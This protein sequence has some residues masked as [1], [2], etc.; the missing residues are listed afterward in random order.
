MFDP[1]EEHTHLS[2]SARKSPK[3]KAAKKRARIQYTKDDVRE[4]RAHSKA[5][6]ARKEYRKGDEEIGRLTPPKGT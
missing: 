5:K 4:L 3:K 2:E 6:T 1:P